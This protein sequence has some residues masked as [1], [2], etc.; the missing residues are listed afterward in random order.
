MMPSL[1][2]GTVAGSA[3]HLSL[4]WLSA[5]GG[6]GFWIF[7]VAGFAYAFAL[8]CGFAKRH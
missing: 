6:G 2:L 4:A 1:L 3:S 8:Q 5:N 7:A